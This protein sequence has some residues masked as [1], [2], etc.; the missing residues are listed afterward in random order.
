MS[1]IIKRLEE[2]VGAPLFDHVKNHIVLNESGHIFFKSVEQIL[3]LVENAEDEI[4]RLNSTRQAIISVTIRSASKYL[5]EL[6]LGFKEQHPDVRFVL[7][8]KKSDAFTTETDFTLCSS[9]EHQYPQPGS[10]LLACDEMFVTVSKMHKFAGREDIAL[11]ETAQEGYICHNDFNDLRMLLFAFC[12]QAGF[13]PDIIFESENS[14]TI[15]NLLAINAGIALTPKLRTDKE[16]LISHL[17]VTDVSCIRY[18]HLIPNPNPNR[19]SPLMKEFQ[20][21]AAS[22]QYP[23][24]DNI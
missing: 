24:M 13:T 11:A 22:F 12:A 21:F 8:E 16:S 15:S 5:G 18:V 10:I 3:K 19:H 23:D 9:L 7:F 1:R 2:E 20:R 4:A 17:H 14:S 6:L